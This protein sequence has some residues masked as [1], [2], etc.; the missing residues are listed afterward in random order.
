MITITASVEQDL[1]LLVLLRIQNVVTEPKSNTNNNAIKEGP[2][3]KIRGKVGALCELTP[4]QPWM[5]QPKKKD[6]I[7]KQQKLKISCK[8]RNFK[9]PRRT[10]VQFQKLRAGLA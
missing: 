8:F 1:L 2:I 5:V 4:Y 3:N 6:I 7:S 9:K 10:E